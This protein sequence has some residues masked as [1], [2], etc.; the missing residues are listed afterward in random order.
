MKLGV[1][2]LRECHV[3]QYV[4][5]GAIHD[6]GEFG[7]LGPDLIGN[8]A[9]PDFPAWARTSRVKCARQRCQL[10][11]STVEPAAFIPSWASE[12]A[13]FTPWSPRRVSLPTKAVQMGSA[14]EVTIS[15][16]E[17]SRR[18]S[19]LLPVAMMTATETTRPRPRAFRSVHQSRE[20]ASRP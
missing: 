15:S 2:F 9:G 12:T 16:P 3:N 6:G 17:T 13:S 7:Y 19:L 14:S 1:V 18:P 10:A 5:F 8:A 11:H 4:G 20:K